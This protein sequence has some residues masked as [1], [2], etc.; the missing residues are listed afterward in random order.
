[1]PPRA[2]SL[3]PCVRCRPHAGAR[4]Q[5]GALHEH[6]SPLAGLGPAQVAAGAARGAALAARRAVPARGEPGRCARGGAAREA[7]MASRLR[8]GLSRAC[9][10]GPLARGAAGA[11]GA[12]VRAGGTGGMQTSQASERAACCSD[13]E[14][15]WWCWCWLWPQV[16]GSVRAAL[17][18]ARRRMRHLLVRACHGRAAWRTGMWCVRAR[19]QG[20]ERRRQARVPAPPLP[21]AGARPGCRWWPA[22]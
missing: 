21:R 4:P 16:R 15:W 8:R 2:R 22:R 6:A 12:R 18:P 7:V 10:G 5:A 19:G 1:M 13:R 20:S 17:W 11:G 3:S 9:A 14:W